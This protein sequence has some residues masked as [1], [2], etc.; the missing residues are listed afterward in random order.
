M[1]LF[2]NERFKSLLHTKLCAFGASDTTDDLDGESRQG[3]W[4]RPRWGFLKTVFV[5]LW[6][7]GPVLSTLT[8][9]MWYSTSNITEMVNSR[10]YNCEANMCF[11]SPILTPK[12]N[13][14]PIWT[15]LTP[16]LTP[17]IPFRP[18]LAPIWS[19]LVPVLISDLVTPFP[20][21]ACKP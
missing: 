8:Q 9:L 13:F 2:Y 17:L 14:D 4:C 5:C 12:P 21:L 7:L 6:L 20:E 18:T 3:A 16:F 1:H 19:P 10:P 15:P 11:R